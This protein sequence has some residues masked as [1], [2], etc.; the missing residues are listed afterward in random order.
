MFQLNTLR[1]RIAL[2]YM[3][4]L[5]VIM[6]GLTLYLTQQ[7]RTVTLTNL[8]ATLL[9]ESKLLANNQ[10]L[11]SGLY[12]QRWKVGDADLQALINEWGDLLNVRVTLIGQDGVVLADSDAAAVTMEDHSQRPEVIS[13]LASGAGESTRYSRTHGFDTFYVAALI[14]APS[15]DPATPP[16]G[17]LRLSMPLTDAESSVMPLRTAV[18]VGGLIAMIFT[19]LLSVIVA[20]RIAKPI[21]RLTEI[22]VQMSRGNWSVRI[23]PR[24][25]DEV[26]QLLRAFNR[27]ADRLLEQV[28]SLQRE[29]ERL[30][31][32][33]NNMVDG[34]LLLDDEGRVQLI[35]P[36]AARLLRIHRKRSV[37]LSFPQVA[38][39]HRLVGLWRRSQEEASTQET[40]LD[41]E[42]RVI[43]A[44]STPDRDGQRRGYHVILQDLTQLRRLETVRRD[45]VSNISHELRTPL[46]SLR[47]LVETLRDGALDDPPAAQRF[48]DR[49]ETE[50]DSLAQMV[51]ELLELSRIESG[52]V[53]FRLQPTAVSEIVLRPVERLQPQAERAR[54][55]LIVDLP[56]G[57]PLVMADGE[58]IHQ[59]LTNLVHNAIKFTLAGGTI[60]VRAQTQTE[61]ARRWV[62]FA[63][64]DTGIGISAE[65][66]PRIFE[67]FYK[68]DQAR[69]AG[70][71]GLGL[72]ISKHIVQAHEGRI[73]AE[74]VEGEG[75]TFYFSLPTL[76]HETTRDV[77]PVQPTD[78]DAWA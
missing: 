25:H 32:I 26:G 42:R 16:L 65:A 19:G 52:R 69:S 54:V 13:A 60:T 6:V 38:R 1:W 48:L 30:S 35:N 41:M 2:A 9:A 63:V 49:I 31:T 56:G 3:A 66:L 36:A 44:V 51:Q 47:A 45:F 20:E 77:S 64:A 76:P 73:W 29:Q 67:R 28:S 17:V 40:M 15:A 10:T 70:G 58:R 23:H 34:V 24:S 74:S 68:E 7:V 57:L 62:V 21:R 5:V 37:D 72:A 27:M 50:V 33:L 11:R 75:S 43:R 55:E 18:V 46:A 22:A 61:Q 53:P 78:P 8:Q 59:V 12:A 71:T 39:D 14:P 4:L